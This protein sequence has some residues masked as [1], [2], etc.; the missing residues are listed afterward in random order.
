M[1]AAPPDAGT[2]AGCAAADSAPARRALDETP[3]RVVGELGW[4]V[5]AGLLSTAW[6]FRDVLRSRFALVP[7][8]L[9]DARLLN[10]LLEHG[11]LWLRRQPLHRHFWDLPMFYPAG[12]DSFA[13][14]DLLLSFAPPYWMARAAGLDPHTG[15]QVW[16]LAMAVA[17]S[18]A[19]FALLRWGLG[20]SSWASCWGANLAT[21]SASRLFQIHHAQLWPI[22]YPALALLA[23]AVYFRESSPTRRR[24]LLA[25]VVVG[26]VLQFWGGF[27]N[28]V[29]MLL[30]GGLLWLA[31]LAWRDARRRSFERLRADALAIA[32][33]IAFGALLLAPL[34]VAYL[35]AQRQVGAR[36]WED[37]EP[38]QPRLVSW[39]YLTPSAPLAAWT[40]GNRLFALLPSRDEHAIGL[41][42]VTS[43]LLLAGVA[44]GWRRPALRVATIAMA[45]AALAVT[46]Y[47]GGFSL[48]RHLA[49]ALPGLSAVRATT[50]LGLLLPLL[51]G[52]AF[53]ALADR[54]GRRGRVWV[55]GLGLLALYE[56]SVELHAFD[57]RVA[58]RWVSHIARRVDPRAA[59]FAVSTRRPG[60]SSWVVQLDAIWATLESGKPTVNGYSGN[61]APGWGGQLWA[62]RTG[63]P[64]QHDRFAIDLGTWLES[65]AQAP[66]T[67]Q[68][69][70]LEP[71]YRRGRRYL[72]SPAETVEPGAAPP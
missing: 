5:L 64:E 46:L 18:V 21:F 29:F 3:R 63:K 54:A 48:W 22:V 36:T 68:W 57:K 16:L 72:D 31:S 65:H 44:A 10:F 47:P 24:W 33:A 25:G 30:L 58:R 55:A 26:V 40:K 42:L 61:W 27:Y 13:Y 39:I 35:R 51:A 20:T 6:F 28:G 14:S 37:M 56:Q 49:A 62:A 45:L 50:R 59:A 52:A 32:A 67:V 66:E 41:G 69:I 15:Y 71:T 4:A 12:A 38:F 19:V 34:A 7:G 53:A 8:E 43:A 17:S 70:E 11:W 9:G 2:P 23:A 60:F 1:T